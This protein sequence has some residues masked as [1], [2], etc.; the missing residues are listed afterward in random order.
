MT[1]IDFTYWNP[2]KTIANHKRYATYSP[3]MKSLFILHL[4]ERLNITRM[5]EW[6]YV[7][8]AEVRKNGGGGWL[9][10]YGGSLIRGI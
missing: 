8:I 3:E 5:D 4:E 6:R 7:S 10:C 9:Q 2:F 1:A